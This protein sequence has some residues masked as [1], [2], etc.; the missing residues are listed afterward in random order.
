MEITGTVKRVKPTQEVSSSFSKR[1]IH[2]TTTGEYPQTL[3][4]EFT[5][6]KCSLL[7]NIGAGE[8]VKIGI[9]LRGREWESPQGEVKVFNTI[10]GW[11]IDVVGSAPTP[12][13]EPS[14][15]LAF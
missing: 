6:D 13:A 4:I 1:E 12:A 7:D 8:D 9:N 3:C 15:D 14:N 5:Q 2:I 10:Q 11:K